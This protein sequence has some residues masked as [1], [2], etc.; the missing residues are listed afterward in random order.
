MKR[1][2]AWMALIFL[3]GCGSQLTVESSTDTPD[4][5][6]AYEGATDPSVR[7]LFHQNYFTDFNDF[8]DLGAAIPAFRQTRYQ[9]LGDS[10]RAFLTSGADYS[11]AVPDPYPVAIASDYFS[12]STVPA[13]VRAVSVD[14]TR[15]YSTLS[16]YGGVQTDG[17]SYRNAGD[18]PG[19]SGCADFDTLLSFYRVQDDQCTGQ[20]SIRGVDVEASKAYVGGVSIDLNRK[21]LG[22]SEDLLLMVTY[23][24]FV[25]GNSSGLGIGFGALE[26]MHESQLEVN[27]VQ[28]SLSLD[29]LLS[30]PQP[31]VWRDF[32]NSAAPV[33][34]RR[35]AT[36]RDPFSSLRTE[37]ILIP[38]SSNPLVDRIRIERVRGSYQLFQIDLYKLGN[39]G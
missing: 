22:S 35:L 19:P 10:V 31:R 8:I 38:L 21:Y 23:Q 16:N 36:L 18:S 25:K 28:T 15:T 30:R 14:M 13:V 12:P 29:L 2:G 4:P 26:E 39:R 9:C 6:L 37:Q 5:G 11:S 33:L 17:C 1:W 34:V 20:G 7:F 3:A 24:A 27:L 32:Q